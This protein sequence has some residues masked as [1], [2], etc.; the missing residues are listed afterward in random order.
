[1]KGQWFYLF[2]KIFFLLLVF[3]GN[4]QETILIKFNVD[5][6]DVQGPISKV[7][8]RG[9]LPPFSWEKTTLLQDEDNDGIYTGSISVN[10]KIGEILSY[11]Y[12]YGEVNWEFDGEK[13][14]KLVLESKNMATTLEKWNKRVNL[15]GENLDAII[16]PAKGLTEDF[17]IIRESLLSLHPG[18][19]RY[20]DSLTWE[21]RFQHLKM[22]LNQDLSIKDT[23]LKISAFLAQIKCGHTYCNFWNQGD[24]IQAAIF[25]REDKLPFTFRIVNRKW[26][27]TGNLSNDPSFDGPIELLAINGFPVDSILNK[28]MQ[29]VKS[30]GSNDNKRINDLQLSGIGEYEAF[31]VYFPLLFPPVEG[32]YRIKAKNWTQDHVFEAAVKAIS[33]KSRFKIMESK[34]GPQVQKDDDLWVFKILEPT[35]GYLKLGTFTVW[36][37]EVDWKAF[38][39]NVF[40][41]LNTKKI[42]NLIIDIRGNEGGLDEVGAQLAKYIVKSPLTIE[43]M[44]SKLRYNNVPETLRPFLSTWDKS[45]FDIRNQVNAI[46]GGY[47]SFKKNEGEFTIQPVSDHFKGNVFLLID[48]ANSSAT[49]NLAK[50]FKQHNLATLIGEPTGGNLRG[51]NGG[52]MFFVQLPHSK[53]EF[54]IPLISSHPLEEQPDAGLQP[55][56]TVM[57]NLEDIFSGKDA[58]LEKAK[59]IIKNEFRKP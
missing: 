16:I 30:D 51:I 57:E 23:Y 40:K 25:D 48:G 5:F 1:M 43:T 50:A 58:V 47:Y 44:V 56:I 41:T 7:G 32:Q 9:N 14:R 13:D 42:K 22:K 27:V 31:D 46:G 11:K 29:F 4:A 18:L 10:A 15:S 35:T 6:T 53:I 24:L 52:R 19:F 28:L 3:I 39:K 17:N 8:V 26:G 21:Q 37:M 12:V 54:D 55:D 36:T 33:R 59:F 49:F 20:A 2:I 45:F 34:Y 38:L